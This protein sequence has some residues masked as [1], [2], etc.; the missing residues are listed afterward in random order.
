[1]GSVS[2]TGNFFL[3]LICLHERTKLEHNLSD[4]RCYLLLQINYTGD[5]VDILIS[6]FHFLHYFKIYQTL[7]KLLKR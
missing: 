5:V 1:M 7:Y 2:N 4:S 3:P 6:L